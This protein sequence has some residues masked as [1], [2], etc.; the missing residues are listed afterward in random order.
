VQHGGHGH[1]HGGGGSGGAS[2]GH[3]LPQQRLVAERK[4]RLGWHARGHPS[5]LMAE[6][7]RVLQVCCMVYI[8]VTFVTKDD[9]CL[10][11]G[12]YV[13]LCYVCWAVVAVGVACTGSP[14]SADGR[15]VQSAAA[16]TD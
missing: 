6:L 3:G 12:C 14:F 16:G 8:V 10:R 7:Y 2:D 4:W 9:V 5:A 15:A 11:C 13:M 1:G